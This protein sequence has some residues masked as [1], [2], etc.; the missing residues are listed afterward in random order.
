MAVVSSLLHA[1]PTLPTVSLIP[2][3]YTLIP[4]IIPHIE[5]NTVLAFLIGG[6]DDA[7]IDESSGQPGDVQVGEDDDV[8][9]EESVG[10]FVGVEHEEEGDGEQVE[11][12]HDE[13]TADSYVLMDCYGGGPIP[14]RA[15]HG[16]LGTAICISPVVA[17]ALMA[18]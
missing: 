4:H 9:D 10:G 8:D 16:A 2:H 3:I 13:Q 1:H 6:G 12:G 11:D 18:D 15:R 17:A 14:A 7:G 5:V